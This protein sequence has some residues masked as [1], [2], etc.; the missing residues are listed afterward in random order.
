MEEFFA[1]IF[2]AAPNVPNLFY[3]ESLMLI[4][5]RFGEY[6]HGVVL[7]KPLGRTLQEIYAHKGLPFPETWRD[8]MI[9]RG[10]NT[11]T[12]QFYALHSNDVLHETS[13]PIHSDIFLTLINKQTIDLLLSRNGPK[14]LQL[15]IN[16]TQEK[17]GVFEREAALNYWG[18]L[19][20]DRALLFA[21]NH[22][23]LWESCKRKV[24][25]N[26]GP[27]TP[28]EGRPLV[29]ISESLTSGPLQ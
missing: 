22:Q 6:M 3:R 7:N 26:L 15:F 21:K 4:A 10:G 1:K 20:F 13:T 27:D 2:V 17:R 14:D 5:G 25:E 28:F 16:L 24:E 8:R 12:T 29:V 9:F 11:S 19:P 23:D 18:V